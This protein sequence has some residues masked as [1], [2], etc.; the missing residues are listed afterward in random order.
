MGFALST[1]TARP[2]SKAPGGQAHDRHRFDAVRRIPRVRTLAAP[3]T[4]KIGV[5][6]WV[7]WPDSACSI[8]RAPRDGFLTLADSFSWLNPHHSL[9]LNLD[10]VRSSKGRRAIPTGASGCRRSR[11]LRYAVRHVRPLRR[12]RLAHARCREG[13][14]QRFATRESLRRDETQRSGQGAAPRRSV[15]LCNPALVYVYPELTE[16]AGK[17]LRLAQGWIRM[18]A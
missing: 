13:D 7:A 15:P 9:V 14:T 5:R 17:S 6:V 4:I 12:G 1:A 11:P 3:S 10:G 8:L 2:P 16:E 18:A